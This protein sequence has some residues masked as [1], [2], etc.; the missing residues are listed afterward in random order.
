[1]ENIILVLN[2]TW[3][4][5]RHHSVPNQGYWLNLLTQLLLLNHLIRN[6]FLLKVHCSNNNL[7]QHIVTIGVYLSL[8]N[9]AIYEHR[10]LENIKKF[11]KY[12]GKC[13]DQQQYKDIIRA[14]MVYTLERF[15]DYSPISPG[16]YMTVKMSSAKNH[17]V[18]FLRFWM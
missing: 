3:K 17:S 10:C 18:N 14:T 5:P 1:M 11:Y 8:S 13:E 16:Q 9:S 4:L 7:K 2:L 12:D 15:T 6:V